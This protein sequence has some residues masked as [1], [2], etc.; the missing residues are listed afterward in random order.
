MF[1]DSSGNMTNENIFKRRILGLSSYFKSAQETLMP[2][3]DKDKD[4]HVINIEMSEYQFGIYEA[5]RAAERKQETNNKKKAAK[6]NPD[7]ELYDDSVSTYR[8]FSRAF[9]NFVFPRPIGRP[10]PGNEA[11]K[12]AAEDFS[13]GMEKNHK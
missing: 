3:F 13:E 7:G 11:I 5:A 9:C 10:M 2:D 8:I 6:K 4:I 12:M 1:I